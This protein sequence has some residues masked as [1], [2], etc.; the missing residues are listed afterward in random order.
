M[1]NTCV[2]A[3]RLNRQWVGVDIWD[4]THDVVIKRLRDEVGLFGEVYYT[5]D[6]LYL[7][8]KQSIPAPRGRK[9]FRAEMYELL[10][11]QQGL[12]CQ[13]CDRTFDD[14]SYLALDHNTPRADGGSNHLSNRILLCGP[15]N[16]LKSHR[17][18]LSG[19]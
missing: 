5:Q 13:G 7:K 10:L 2:A 18:T 1:R 6:V 9:M 16:R 15:C 8:V 3:E 19:L 14:P 17:Y 12:M 4:K 11:S